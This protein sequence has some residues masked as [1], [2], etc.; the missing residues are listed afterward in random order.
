M[1]KSNKILLIHGYGAELKFPVSILNMAEMQIFCFSNMVENNQ[2]TL[3][4][5]S[6]GM[7]WNFVQF[8]NPICH[9]KLFNSE[10]ETIY[11]GSAQKGWRNF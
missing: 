9:L 3:F 10:K 8:A 11:Q 7:K 4:N 1:E 2:A 5:W 6:T